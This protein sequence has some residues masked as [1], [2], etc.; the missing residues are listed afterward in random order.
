MVWL[1]LLYRRWKFWGLVCEYTVLVMMRK[2][3]VNAEIQ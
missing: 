1:L 3:I 2:S